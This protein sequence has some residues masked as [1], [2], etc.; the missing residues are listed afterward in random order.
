MSGIGSKD[1]NMSYREI[2]S[3]MKCATHTEAE[4]RAIE[5][6][7]RSGELIGKLVPVGTWILEDQTKISL[8]GSWRQRTMRMFLTQ[9]ESTAERT[10]RYLRDVAIA[11]DQRLLFLIYDQSGRFVGHMGIADVDG[12]SA[13]LDN[14]MRGSEGGDPRLVYFAELA[15]LD[16]CFRILNLQQSTV[17][18]L[19]YNWLVVSLHE[20]V[21]F[22]VIESLPLMKYVKDGIVFHDVVD[23][24]R[25]N[26]KYSYIKLI[27]SKD[28]FT[29]RP[30]R[31]ASTKPT[32]AE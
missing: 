15:L 9:F 17:Q 12:S 3:A 29:V 8:M 7:N 5:I 23:I 11:Q 32:R 27:L 26:V 20:D 16:W 28:E 21:G 14:F 31:L 10:E 24:Q 25:S 19:S 22:R 4:K 13:E 2:I 6:T 1:H 30:N 18:V